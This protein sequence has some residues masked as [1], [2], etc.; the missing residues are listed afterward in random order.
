MRRHTVLVSLCARVYII[1]KGGCQI[2]LCSTQAHPLPRL[3]HFQNIINISNFDCWTQVCDY[4]LLE[5]KSRSYIWVANS[6][7]QRLIN[8][9]PSCAWNMWRRCKALVATALTSH[10]PPIFPR[11]TTTST[12][13]HSHS[14]SSCSLRD[15]IAL[16]TKIFP[17]CPPR[18][19]VRSILYL[20]SKEGNWV[21]FQSL[22]EEVRIQV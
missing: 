13:Y 3:P 16:R 7:L 18:K 20:L 8:K 1:A 17:V 22:R 12:I 11:V 5:H 10:A 15:S 9:L 14:D 6:S 19:S 4:W 21:I 2:P